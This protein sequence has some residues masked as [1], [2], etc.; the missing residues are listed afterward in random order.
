MEKGCTDS[1][2]W[3]SSDFTIYRITLWAVSQIGLVLM[4]EKAPVHWP[5][6]LKEKLVS[7]NASCLNVAYD[8]STEDIFDTDSADEEASLILP[9]PEP[10]STKPPTMGPPLTESPLKGSPPMDYLPVESLSME[11]GQTDTPPCRK[12]SCRNDSISD[13]NA[14]NGTRS[15][16]RPTTQTS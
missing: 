2:L 16:N 11:P 15:E 10:P 14:G 9:A 1:G 4:V 12:P 5:R 7:D 3:E 6:F 13:D 8:D